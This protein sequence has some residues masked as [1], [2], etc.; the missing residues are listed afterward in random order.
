MQDAALLSEGE[1]EG[2]DAAQVMDSGAE[3]QMVQNVLDSLLQDDEPDEAQ[4]QDQSHDTAPLHS[5]RFSTAT[6]ASTVELDVSLLDKDTL[7]TAAIPSVD[8]EHA[9]PLQRAMQ[10]QLAGKPGKAAGEAKPS[11]K[12]DEVEAGSKQVAVPANA[13][14]SKVQPERPGKNVDASGEGAG[15]R[16]SSKTVF[17]RSLPPDVS[18][19]QLH[20][21][22][23]KFGKLRACRSATHANSMDCLM[24][25]ICQA[26]LCLARTLWYIGICDCAHKT[27]C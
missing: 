1:D 2:V 15:A 6:G 24:S 5:L 7:S 23:K 10:V 19:D 11:G 20:I 22:F 9:Q 27:R 18:Q 13:A 16:D 3:Q 25:L 21:A 12:G 8:C 17:V 4:V 26:C 14:A